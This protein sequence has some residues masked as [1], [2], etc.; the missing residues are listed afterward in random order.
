[1]KL[2]TWLLEKGVKQADISRATGI[3]PTRISKF[4]SGVQMLSDGQLIQVSTFLDLSIEELL[5]NNIDQNKEEQ[6]RDEI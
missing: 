2:K 5:T 4:I 3:D 1:M 6:C